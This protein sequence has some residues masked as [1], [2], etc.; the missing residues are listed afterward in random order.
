MFCPQKRQTIH[1]SSSAEFI[2]LNRLRAFT[3]AMNRLRHPPWRGRSFFWNGRN[4]AG[5]YLLVPLIFVLLGIEAILE[6]HS[7]NVIALSLIV[8]APVIL[9][10]FGLF[11]SARK[12][13]VAD[14]EQQPARH[15]RTWERVRLLKIGARAAAILLIVEYYLAGDKIIP[16]GNPLLSVL[17][18]IGELY[19]IE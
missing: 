3:L 14:A 12:L 19:I 8:E 1:P 7:L 13:N 18:S 5:L 9:I 17:F 2:N 11:L 6:L 4:V 15:L 10:G 16:Q